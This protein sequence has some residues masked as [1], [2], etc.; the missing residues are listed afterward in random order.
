MQTISVLNLIYPKEKEPTLLVMPRSLLFN[1]QSEI[2][3]FA[4]EL[5]VYTYYGNSRDMS[6]ALKHQLVLTTYAIVRNDVEQFKEQQFHYVILDESQNIKNISAQITQSVLMLNARHR[7]ALSGT[8][9]ENNLTELYSLFRF[10]NPAMFG[11]LDDFN[12]RYANPIQR[13]NDKDAMQS[14]RRRIFPFMLRR[15]KRDV[16]KDLPDRTDK[17]LYVEMEDMQARFMKSAALITKN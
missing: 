10:L 2:A 15:L 1:W 6:E 17:T 4:P 11:T 5:R 3:R 13:D 14:L 12:A 16:L 9:V 7:L 8:P